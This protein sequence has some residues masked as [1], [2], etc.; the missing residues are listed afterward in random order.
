MYI[1]LNRKKGDKMNDLKKKYASVLLKSCLK[2]EKEPLFISFNAERLD[3]VRIVAEVAYSMGVT[4][5]YFDIVEPYLKHDALK[6]LSVEDCK[7]L[8][9]WNRSKWNEYARKGASFLMLAS[10]TPGLMA[11]IDPNKIKEL[12]KYSNETRKEFEEMRDK[13]LVPW[14]IAAVPTISW[15]KTLFPESAR[16]LDDL[17]MKIFEICEITKDN[18]EDIWN[19]KIEVLDGMAKKLNYYQFKTLKYKNSLGTDFE[20][21]LPINHIWASGREQLKSKREVLCNFPT[22][23]V[24]TSPDYRTANGIVYASKP[25]SYQDNIIE[26]FSVIF[27]NGKVV[28]VHA[29]KGE[30][31][32]KALINTCRNMDYLGEVALVEYDSAISKS[33]MVFLETL[34]DENAACHIALGD[35]FPECIKDGPTTDKDELYKLGLNKCDNHVDFMIGTKDLSII[36]ITHDN[37]EIKIFEN[38]NFTSEFK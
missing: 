31:I 2:V 29:E 33:G 30:Q 14:C 5:I 37:K 21:G 16:P 20:I 27:E 22:E 36:G 25:L 34:F 17:W 23:E 35:S 1:M 8:T 9:L 12:V 28:E 38:G 3:F 18:P 4:D 6:N 19:R 26:N 13:S 15:A 24:F 7:K 32:L 11:D 10:E